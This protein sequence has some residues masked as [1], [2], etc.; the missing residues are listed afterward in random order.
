MSDEE[1]KEGRAGAATPPAAAGSTGERGEGRLET[2]VTFLEMRRPAHV[3]VPPPASL[4]MTLMRAEKPTVHFYRYLYDTIGESHF[5]VDRKRL[6]DEELAAIIQ[7]ETVSVF[8]AYAHGVP[9]GFFE[10]EERAPGE[11]W[12]AYF[13]I[14]PEFQGRGLGKWLLAE[15]I[16]EAFSRDP[17][18]LRVE[19]CTLDD[20][21]AL[22]LYQ[23]MGFVPYERTK[24]VIVIET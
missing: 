15:A 23:K 10:L 22:P 12:L 24:R 2:V 3:F 11:I 14:M 8:V 18:V 21:R 7:R 6:S 17:E 9:A 4:R 20:P 5:W 16:D 13:G 1:R 19:T